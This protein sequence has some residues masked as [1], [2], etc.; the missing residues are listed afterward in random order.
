MPLAD[1]QDYMKFCQSGPSNL[2]KS[3]KVAQ[4]AR[5][6]QQSPIGSPMRGRSPSPSAWAAS[7]PA[8][9]SLD[10]SGLEGAITEQRAIVLRNIISGFKFADN[11]NDGRRECMSPERSVAT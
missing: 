1:L 4:I 2:P 5:E 10:T 6:L 8:V 9:P 11:D 7:P 3:S